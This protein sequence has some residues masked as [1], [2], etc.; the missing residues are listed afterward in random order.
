MIGFSEDDFYRCWYL[1]DPCSDTY[2]LDFNHYIYSFC[3]VVLINS[4]HWNSEVNIVK[5]K[6]VGI[7]ESVIQSSFSSIWK[8]F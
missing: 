2:I 6:W 7:I 8:A 4:A 5:V 3:K 1:N